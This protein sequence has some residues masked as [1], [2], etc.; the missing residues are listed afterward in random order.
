MRRIDRIVIHCSATKVT[1][2]YTPEQ[3]LHDHLARG[4]KTYGYHYYVRKDG[5]IIPMRPLDEIGAHAS[6]YNANSAGICY[7]GGL[8]ASGKPSDTRTAEQKKAML[9]L[10]QEL[11]TRY[12]IKHIDGH[13][14]LSPDT[15]KNGIVEP[16]EWVKLC[17]CFDVKEL[18]VI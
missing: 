4:F 13:R 7:E 2:N 9:S 11:K 10:L 5:T 8:D 12:P 16:V 3:L 15:N 6:G 17:P 1:S 18:K 14:D